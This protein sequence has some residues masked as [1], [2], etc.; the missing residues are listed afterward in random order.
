M[1]SDEYTNDY[2]EFT[3]TG[4]NES[5][6]DIYYE[7]VL[8]DGEDISSKERINDHDLAFKLVQ[9]EDEEEITLFE[10]ESLLALRDKDHK[11]L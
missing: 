2:F 1:P 6:R 7:I 4:K 9:V 10:D 3:I 8:L 5:T 11:L